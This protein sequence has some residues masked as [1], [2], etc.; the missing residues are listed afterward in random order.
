MKN[1]RLIWVAIAALA[2]VL[3]GAAV[4]QKTMHE[5][6]HHEMGF[7]G[8]FAGRFLGFMADYLDLSDAQQAQIKTILQNE[9]PNFDPLVQNLMQAHHDIEAA[10]DAGTLDQTQ[11]LSIIEA[12]KDAFAQLLVEKAKTQAQIMAVLTPDQQAQLKKLRDR[13]E[14][15]MQKMMQE[16]IQQQQ[17]PAAPEAK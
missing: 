5:M 11:A 6:R 2:V 4:A 14:Q 9:K 16:H 7:E 3:G 1:K 12:H 17:P 15:R 8:P 10:T 13:H